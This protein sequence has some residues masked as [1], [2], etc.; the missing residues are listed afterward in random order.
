VQEETRVCWQWAV[1]VRRCEEVCGGLSR[2]ELE[3]ECE[4]DQGGG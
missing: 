1:R 4:A 3:G 2:T